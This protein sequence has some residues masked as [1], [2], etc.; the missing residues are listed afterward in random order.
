MWFLE[1][2]CLGISPYPLIALSIFNI[3]GPK[4]ESTELSLQGTERVISTD[5]LAI[6]PRIRA[7]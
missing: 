7:E 5:N 3:K 1:L 6:E 2:S 4:C